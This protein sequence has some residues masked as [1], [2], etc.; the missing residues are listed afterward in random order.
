MRVTIDSHASGEI[1][2]LATLSSA[3]MCTICVLLGTLGAVAQPVACTQQVIDRLETEAN[4]VRSWS[5]L[6]NFFHRYTK[7]NEE[8]AE[9]ETAVGEFVTRT[10]V[11]HWESLPRA[12]KLFKQD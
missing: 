12:A 5:A 1:K 3:V 4:A 10:L 8:D 11:N 2:L 7:C 9:V 6:H